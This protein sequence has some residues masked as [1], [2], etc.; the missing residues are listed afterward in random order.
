MGM[1]RT[2]MKAKGFIAGPKGNDGIAL[3]CT[4]NIQF[5]KTGRPERKNFYFGYLKELCGIL[6]AVDFGT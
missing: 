1:I 2:F 4:Y 5:S 6:P 3:C